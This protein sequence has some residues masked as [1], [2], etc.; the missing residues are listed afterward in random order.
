MQQYHDEVTEEKERL[1]QWKDNVTKIVESR[2]KE[3]KISEDQLKSLEQEVIKLRKVI[4]SGD[5]IA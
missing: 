1:T 3:C 5:T 2:E 4:E